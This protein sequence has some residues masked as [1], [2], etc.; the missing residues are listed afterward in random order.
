M[1]IWPSLLNLSPPSLPHHLCATSHTSYSDY[2]NSLPNGPLLCLPPSHLAYATKLNSIPKAQLWSPCFLAQTPL[3]TPQSIQS[4]VQFPQSGTWTPLHNLTSTNISVLPLWG[5]LPTLL[6]I[7][8]SGGDQHWSMITGACICKLGYGLWMA[9]RMLSSHKTKILVWHI[10]GADHRLE[11]HEQRGQC[12]VVTGEGAGPTTQGF[13]ETLWPTLFFVLMAVEPLD[14][15]KYYGQD[16]NL[17]FK[18]WSCG[19]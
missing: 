17:S 10:Q 13:R 1:L 3:M 4:N 16:H 8:S 18:R 5:L 2:I 11:R 19:R 14:G 12:G 7:T 9:E 6:Q 15:F